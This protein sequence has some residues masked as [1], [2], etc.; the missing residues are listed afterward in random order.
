[1]DRVANST[2]I[3]DFESRLNSLRVNRLK[4]LDLPTPESPISTTAK[5][6]CQSRRLLGGGKAG[7]SAVGLTLEKELDTRLISISSYYG[8]LRSKTY[9]VFVIR[10][11]CGCIELC[12]GK[13]TWTDGNV[14]AMMQ[15]PFF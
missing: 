15:R 14:V 4:R 9:I 2:P 13:S 1:M 11:D 10:H 12:C 3:V 5:R 7:G 8:V 6:I